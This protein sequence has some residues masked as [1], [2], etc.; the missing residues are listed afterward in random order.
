MCGDCPSLK[1]LPAWAKL[2]FRAAMWGRRDGFV[3]SRQK[4]NP[5]RTERIARRPYFEWSGSRL[6]FQELCRSENVV[7]PSGLSAGPRRERVHRSSF[8]AQKKRGGARFD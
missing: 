7:I 4:I 3:D 1:L 5:P 2:R 8:A 6:P